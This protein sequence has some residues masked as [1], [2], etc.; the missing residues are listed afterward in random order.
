MSTLR[1]QSLV[2]RRADPELHRHVDHLVEVGHLVSLLPGVCRRVDVP[3]EHVLLARAATSW[4]PTGALL[5]ASAA[6]LTW[7]PDL[8]PRVVDFLARPTG[9][10]Q[11]SQAARTGAAPPT[12]GGMRGLPVWSCRCSG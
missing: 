5:G 8:E 4:K 1:S 12:C 10:A 3:V 7:W 2:V 6:A 9:L 11:V